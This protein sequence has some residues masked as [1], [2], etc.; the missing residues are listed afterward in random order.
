MKVLILGGTGAMGIHLVKILSENNNEVHVTTRRNIAD[1]N[2]IRYLQGNAHDITFLRKTIGGGSYDAVVD[3][4]SYKTD[5]FKGRY[6]LLL[7]NTKQYVYLS[8]ARVYADSPIITENSPRLL[9][10]CTDEEYL[11]TDEYA[12]AKA[13][14]ENLLFSSGRK[15]F[16]IIRPYITYSENRL[17]LGVIEKEGWLYRALHGRSIVISDDILPKFTALTYG[18]D[19][20]YCISKLIGNP[21]A[22][23]EVF[24]ISF[25]ESITWSHIL[26]TYCKTLNKS[27]GAPVLVKHIEN[28]INLRYQLPQ[29]QVKYDRWF[30]RSF[31][32]SKVMTAVGNIDYKNL[33]EGLTQCLNAFIQKPHYNGINWK[34][35]A[36]LDRL[37]HEHAKMSEFDGIRGFVRFIKYLYYRWIASSKTL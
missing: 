33:D 15:N 34:R 8:S 9:D 17:Q 12:L 18:Y 20:S 16:T 2:N 24:H 22:M 4:M 13:R 25:G 31:D 6:E 14:Q 37:C 5:E 11:K 30:N 7:E 26:D 29:Y 32:S 10:V 23:G 19:V 3:F 27:L 28:A 21:N 35:E 36:L 1:E